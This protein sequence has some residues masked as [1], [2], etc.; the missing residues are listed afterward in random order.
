M[1]TTTTLAVVICLA[2]GCEVAAEG[3]GTLRIRAYGE[4]FIEDAIPADAVVDGWSITFSKFLVSV[5][6]ISADGMPLE[7]WFVFDLAQSSGGAGHEVGTLTVPAG[8]VEHLDYRVAPS[9]SATA[10]N[11]T[12]ADVELMNGMGWSLRVEGTATRAAES[13]AFA[14]GFDTDTAYTHCHTEQEVSDGGE[15]TS[16]MTLHADHLFYD[17]LELP[18]PNVTFDLVAS[19]DAEPDGEVTPEELRAVDIT[20]LAN[21]GVGSR[22]ITNL[23]TFIAAQT[24]TLGHIDGEGHCDQG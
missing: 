19:A 23:W 14:W 2:T 4:E 21:Y 5:G 9:R 10:G 24:S 3:E 1:K 16:Q 17:D 13:I 15:A 22:D 20:G 18:E 7:G 11:A 12:A 6:E 8:L